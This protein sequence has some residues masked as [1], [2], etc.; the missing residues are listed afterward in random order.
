[1]EKL[2]LG[3]SSVKLFIAD[4]ADTLFDLGFFEDVSFILAKCTNPKV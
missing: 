4:E 1:V 2:D 3:L